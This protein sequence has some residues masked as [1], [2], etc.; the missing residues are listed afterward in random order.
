MA[1]EADQDADDQ[2]QAE[3]FDETHLTEDGED[4]ARLDMMRNV[5]DVTSAED[6]ADDDELADEDP[7]DFDPDALDETERESLFQDDDGIDDDDGP[8]TRDQGDL[9]SVDDARPSDFEGEAQSTGPDDEDLDE[10]AG[11]V[12]RDG[13]RDSELKD[14]FP[15][16]DSLPVNPGSD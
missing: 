7:D 2:D 15:A 14:T 3:T 9:V 11:D 16:S 10:T 6:D 8:V 13:R 1:I 5:Y 4:I 12:R